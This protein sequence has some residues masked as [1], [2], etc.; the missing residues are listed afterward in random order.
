MQILIVLLGLAQLGFAWLP[1]ARASAARPFASL[2]PF[3]T[4]AQVASSVALA[5]PAVAHAD[6]GSAAG[7]VAIPLVISV[8][9]MFPFLYYANQLKPK[10]RTVAQIELDKDLK[11]IKEKSTGSVGQ[12]KAGKKK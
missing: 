7:A 4:A 11:P 1:Q 8:L 3:K 6:T 5:A 10:A 2:A 9:V 12:A